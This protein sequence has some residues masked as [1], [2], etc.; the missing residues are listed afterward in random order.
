MIGIDIGGANIK[1]VTDDEVI[2]R[3][4]PLWEKAPLGDILSEFDDD[5]AIVMSG[6]LADCFN[7]K[8]E[9]VRFIVDA[10]RGALPK[11]RFYGTDAAFHA[12]PAPELAAANWLASADLLKDRYQ[13]ALLIDLGSTTADII[14]L[15]PFEDLKGQTDLSRLRAGYLVYCGMLRTPVSSLVRSAC[16]D[17]YETPLSTEYFASAGDAHLVLGHITSDEYTVA[18]PDGKEATREKSLL[19]LARM[20]CADLDE[21][22]EEGAVAIAEAFWDAQRTLIGD[23]LGRTGRETILA[24]G[25]GAELIHTTFGGINLTQDLGRFADALPAYAVREVAIRNGI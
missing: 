2:I 17:G 8:S 19:R 7:N 9:G 13:D 16:I 14:P 4:C 25:I 11:A 1:I 18:T 24:A 10:V 5:A 21:I 6:E 12:G 20:A 22:G 23:A 3:Y 15:Q